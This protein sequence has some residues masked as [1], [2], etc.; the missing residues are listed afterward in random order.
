MAT[1]HGTTPAN[2]TGEQCDD[3]VA[4]SAGESQRTAEINQRGAAAG[5][6]GHG[7]EESGVAVAVLQGERL[8]PDE[9]VFL[10]TCSLHVATPA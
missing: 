9:T 6:H 5:T 7:D 4:C 8:A 3:R 1:S 10:L 2:S